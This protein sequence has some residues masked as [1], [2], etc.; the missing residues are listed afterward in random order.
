MAVEIYE[1]VLT[2]EQI[3]E[4]LEI[5]DK[6]KPVMYFGEIRDRVMPLFEDFFNK[7]HIDTSEISG[8]FYY[9]K[10]PFTTHSD[11]LSSN[12]G[13]KQSN[14]NIFIPL[15]IEPIGL[16]SHTIFFDQFDETP[17]HGRKFYKRTLPE[18]N[19]LPVE[20][21]YSIL[22]NITDEPFDREIYNEYLR[23]MAHDNLYGLTF[24]KAVKWKVG[25]AIKFESNRLHCSAS[26][27][28]KGIVAKTHIFF[29][30]N[31]LE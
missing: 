19:K 7:W 23:H 31:I 4:L 26:F 9:T 11:G 29:K 5:R 12:N 30:V 17:K 15:E 6:N 8:K 22:T 16:S 13:S 25:S 2:E 18:G 24:H 21:D 10:R 28:K 3:N 27:R 1:N 14:I 20:L